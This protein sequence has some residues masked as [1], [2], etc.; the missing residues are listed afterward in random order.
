MIGRLIALVGIAVM[1]FG[2]FGIIRANQSIAGLNLGNTMN[3]ATDA[4]AREAQLCKPGEKLEE[5]KGASQYTPG[6]GYASSVIMYCVNSEG[7]KRDVTGDF[8]TGMVGQMGGIF[9]GVFSGIMGSVIY[10]A[11][12]GV[13]LVL[14]IIGLILGRRRTGTVSFGVPVAGGTGFATTYTTQNAGGAIDLN[15]VIQQARDMKAAAG[16]SDLTTRLKQLE[17]A[18]NAGLISQTEYDRARQQILDTLK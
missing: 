18:R 12:M 2:I 13:G 5:S 15:Q 1:G 4:K 7:Q 6:Q 17:D 3:L 10:F 14:T 11:L 16:S 9:S 8:A